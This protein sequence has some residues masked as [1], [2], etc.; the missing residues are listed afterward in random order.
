MKIGERV[1]VESFLF[2]GAGVIDYIADAKEWFPI[3]VFLDEPAD[4][5]QRLK[6]VG[7]DEIKPIDAAAPKPGPT[8]K[9]RA[10]VCTPRMGYC[11]NDVYVIGPAQQLPDHFNVYLVQRPGIPIG[12]YRNESM[13]LEIL[14]PFE[15]TR[16][17]QQAEPPKRVH[18]VTHTAPKEVKRPIVAETEKTPKKGAKRASQGEQLSI[19]DF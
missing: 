8:A 17:N 1:Y 18:S 5:G 3:Q 4:D 12:T 10:R 19:F 14:G 2:S 11:M 16:D 6:R 13:F 15:E 7:L 9:Q